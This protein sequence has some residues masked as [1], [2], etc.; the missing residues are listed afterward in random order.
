MKHTLSFYTATDRLNRIV[1]IFA[2]AETSNGVQSY[3]ILKD[4]LLQQT[5]LEE[6]QKPMPFITLDLIQHSQFMEA[7]TKMCNEYNKVDDDA[8]KIREE[9]LAENRLQEQMFKIEKL[10]G[11]L[12]K[13]IDSI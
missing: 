10:R 7:L 5:F 8:K 11:L 4:G 13:T 12:I 2:F 3:I 6:G 1:D 9:A